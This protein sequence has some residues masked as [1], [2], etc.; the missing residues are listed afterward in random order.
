MK[1]HAQTKYEQKI[2]PEMTKEERYDVAMQI[3]EEHT[4]RMLTWELLYHY[5]NADPYDVHNGDLWAI[6][7]RD[8]I[9]TPNDLIRAIVRAILFGHLVETNNL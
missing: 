2:T 7:D 3:S 4:E 6:I 5:Q 1:Q 8:E 9:V